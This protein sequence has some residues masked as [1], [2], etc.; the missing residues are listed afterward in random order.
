MNRVV[1]L[2]FVMLLPF[3][4]RTQDDSK[5]A[6]TATFQYHPY[7]FFLGLG[8][9]YAPQKWEQEARL[10]IGLNRSLFQRRFYPKLTYIFA[11][12]LTVYK[13]LSCAPFL[14]LD[15][16][17]LD[18]SS[19]VNTNRLTWLEPNLG[20]N[21]MNGK[22]LKYGLSSGIGPSW[23]WSSQHSGAIQTW[24]VFAE[25]NLTYAI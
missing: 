22:R 12:R 21:V 11:Y 5:S 16:S 7:D 24:N 3:L 23:E 25:I 19:D 17:F 10:S 8:Y 9:Q 6:I 13:T 1:L 14:R 15:A 2:F 20:I 18:V 4:G